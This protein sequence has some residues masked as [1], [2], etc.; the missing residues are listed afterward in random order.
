MQFQ[1]LETYLVL[2]EDAFE[3]LCECIENLDLTL[4]NVPI[5]VEIILGAA[6]VG[7]IGHILMGEDV[8]DEDLDNFNF[9]GDDE[10]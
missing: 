4:G 9:Y 10:Y 8:T 6:L 2:L 7:A 1:P 3:I 5:T